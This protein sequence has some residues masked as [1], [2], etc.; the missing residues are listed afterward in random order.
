MER[1]F[2]RKLAV[3]AL[4]LSATST[5]CGLI[6]GGASEIDQIIGLFNGGGNG[7]GSTTFGAGTPSGDILH[8]PGGG[9]GDAPAGDTPGGGDG[10]LISEIP[11][12]GSGGS[13][14]GLL[15]PPVQ[16]VH[17]PEPATLALFGTGLFGLAFAR[18]KPH[19][20]S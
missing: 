20:F 11:G 5:G 12:G 1:M 9:S 15:S 19:K 7:G 17:N 2:M 18:R 10:G 4:I 3:L 8:L 16:T 14:L 13:D 6:G